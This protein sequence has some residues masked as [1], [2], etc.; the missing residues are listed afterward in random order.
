MEGTRQ[1][2]VMTQ[3]MRQ[4]DR[5]FGGECSLERLTGQRICSSKVEKDSVRSR[6]GRQEYALKTETRLPCLPGAARDGNPGNSRRSEL[7][8]NRRRGDPETMACRIK[9]SFATAQKKPTIPW[10][11][12]V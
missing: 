10:K 12:G 2:V 7:S 1:I 4:V 5:R 9:Y 11:S 3:K 8:I 6:L